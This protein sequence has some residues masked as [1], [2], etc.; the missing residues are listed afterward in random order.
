M[1]TRLPFEWPPRLEVGERILHV[2]PV[3]VPR[4]ERRGRL[5]LLWDIP[6][7]LA[8]VGLLLG[9]LV[10]P[11][12]IKW[13][14][15]A[16]DGRPVSP[17]SVEAFVLI[18]AAIPSALALLAGAGVLVAMAVGLGIHTYRAPIRWTFGGRREDEQRS[19][20]QFVVTTRRLIYIDDFE[21]GSSCAI[22]FASLAGCVLG[23]EG[24]R[25]GRK[26]RLV[27]K[28]K[29]RNWRG[30]ERTEVIFGPLPSEDDA[31]SLL[32]HIEAARKA[33]AD[34]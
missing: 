8:G 18:L 34:G 7:W 28:R 19:A 17:S 30:R 26:F 6:R 9:V 21:D 12:A 29:E 24:G 13:F 2:L 4:K 10:V 22:S 1:G 16:C 25:R 23:I 14:V 32:A 11:G 33:S 27:A 31:R 15:E 5:W 20:W 3:V